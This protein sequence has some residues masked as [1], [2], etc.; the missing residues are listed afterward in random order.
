[1]LLL[2]NRF[3]P[4]KRGFCL[5]EV[6]ANAGSNVLIFAFDYLQSDFSHKLSVSKN[7]DLTIT[8]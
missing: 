1:M 6:V 7:G 2:D 8:K 4:F 3:C 5:I